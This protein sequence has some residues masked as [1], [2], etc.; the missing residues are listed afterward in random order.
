MIK[1]SLTRLKLTL[2]RLQMAAIMIMLS[3]VYFA[4]ILSGHI[5]ILNQIGKNKPPYVA[6][7]RKISLAGNVSDLLV[8]DLSNSC[9]LLLNAATPVF[10]C[11]FLKLISCLTCKHKMSLLINS[12]NCLIKYLVK[13]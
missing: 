7:L 10:N 2:L 1:T 13:D 9:H 8:T 4:I 12:F 6:G 11:H 3:N 5:F